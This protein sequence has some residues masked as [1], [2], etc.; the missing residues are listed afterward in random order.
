M[1]LILSL[2]VLVVAWLLGS[3]IVAVLVVLAGGGQ[4]AVG[5]ALG[6]LF[7]SAVAIAAGMIADSMEGSSDV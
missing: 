6:F 1:R 7:G 5:L 3:A 4:F 2:F